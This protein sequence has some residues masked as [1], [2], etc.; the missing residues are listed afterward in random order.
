MRARLGL[1]TP[2]VGEAA[3]QRGALQDQQ[4]SGGRWKSGRQ[5]FGS[6]DRSH[7]EVGGSRDGSLLEDR[8]HLEDGGSRDGSLLEDGGS[9]DGSLLEVRTEVIWKTVEVRTAAFWGT[10]EVETVV[11]PWHP[12]L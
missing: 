11:W 9:R 3:V 1:V 10:V 12:S 5:L 7:L 8:S 6:Q 2:A 4:P